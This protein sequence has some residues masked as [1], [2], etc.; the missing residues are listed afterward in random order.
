LPSGYQQKHGNFHTFPLKRCISDYI[1]K[2]TNT[3]R[4]ILKLSAAPLLSIF[5]HI[6]PLLSR[7]KL[8]RQSLYP[9]Q[10]SA[11]YIMYVCK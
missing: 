11:S 3:D 4:K 1:S 10:S 8:V 7:L 2:K 5:Y 9:K 6:I